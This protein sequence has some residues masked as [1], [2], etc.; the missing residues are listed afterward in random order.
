MNLLGSSDFHYKMDQKY[1][2]RARC[3][4]HGCYKEVKTIVRMRDCA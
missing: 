4:Y 2:Q 3:C 1:K